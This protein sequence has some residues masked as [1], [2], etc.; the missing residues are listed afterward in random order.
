MA[1]APLTMA[2]AKKIQDEYGVEVDQVYNPE[3]GQTNFILSE[4]AAREAGAKAAANNFKAN[5]A[6]ALIDIPQFLFATAPFGSVTKGL[7]AGMAKKLGKNVFATGAKNIGAQAL[8]ML[9]EGAEEGYQYISSE[10]SKEVE[11][12]KMGL[13]DEED[14]SSSLKRYVGDGEFAT[15]AIFGALGAGVMV[16]GANLYHKAKAKK[17][18]EVTE[19]DRRVANIDKSLAGIKAASMALVKEETSEGGGNPYAFKRIQQDNF[20]PM[21]VE[22]AENGNLGH[23]V[24]LV[25]RAKEDKEGVQALMGLE[26]KEMA[27]FKK[28]SDGILNILKNVENVYQSNINET[29]DWAYA[30][31]LT[32]SDIGTSVYTDLSNEVTSELNKV[33]SNNASWTFDATKAKGTP[34]QQFK[35]RMVTN[36]EL[37]NWQLKQEYLTAQLGEELGS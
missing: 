24:D 29:G 22:A 37:A 8:N 16:G 32:A 4:E 35:D 13:I 11:L 17:T 19:T 18:G 10:R 27:E 1:G 30:R 25:E 26:D 15:S 34:T 12:A 21:A 23:L 33:A 31:A 20:I 6:L 28:N 3:T 5:Q 14:F 2:Q 7:T 36:S 9:G